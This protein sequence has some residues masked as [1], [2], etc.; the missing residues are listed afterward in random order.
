MAYVSSPTR[1]SS[2]R[3][4]ASVSGSRSVTVVPSP[5]TVRMSTAPPSAR[6][7]L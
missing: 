2:E 6:T 5:G 7:R 1:A 4:M 3:T